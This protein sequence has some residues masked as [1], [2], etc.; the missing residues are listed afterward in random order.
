M[1]EKI[2]AVFFAGSR[3]SCARTSRGDFS[4]FPVMSRRRAS[5][6]SARYRPAKTRST[7]ASCSGVHGSAR[8]WSHVEGASENTWP[9]KVSGE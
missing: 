5:V 7:S 2:T 1:C 8:T 4:T 9:D 3:P 6:E